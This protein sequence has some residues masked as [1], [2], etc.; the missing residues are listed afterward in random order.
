MHWKVITKQSIQTVQIANQE[1][2]NVGH[3]FHVMHYIQP[4]WTLCFGAPKQGCISRNVTGELFLADLGIP[5]I[6]WKKCG[7]KPSHIPWGAEF[8]LALEYEES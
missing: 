2:T 7:V 6:S 1:Y 3:P 8:I 4:K 5:S